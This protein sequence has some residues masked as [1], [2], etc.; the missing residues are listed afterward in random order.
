YVTFE[1]DG[2]P[3][4][5]PLNLL[6]GGDIVA[7]AVDP[8]A[9]DLVDWGYQDNK[10]IPDDPGVTRPMKLLPTPAQTAA[11]LAHL[12]TAVVTGVHDAP[13][14]AVA[15]ISSPTNLITKPITEARKTAGI[16][17]GALPSASGATSGL[18]KVA[19]SVNSGL[20]GVAGSLKKTVQKTA[21]A[22][23]S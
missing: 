13:A 8:A 3:L 5:R 17:T 14:T 23:G 21:A 6:P 15:D 1:S 4:T 20:N 12:P 16:V 7:S 11:T 18:K 19:S 9:T 2:L 10:P 22:G